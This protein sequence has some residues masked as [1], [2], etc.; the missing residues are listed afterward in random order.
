MEFGTEA[1]P[2]EVAVAKPRHGRVGRD[3][4]C[5]QAPIRSTGEP[6]WGAAPGREHCE[7]EDGHGAHH[8]GAGHSSMA[9]DLAEGLAVRQLQRD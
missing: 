1:R 8:R 9:P 3:L 5:D 2:P 7:H 6:E 4:S